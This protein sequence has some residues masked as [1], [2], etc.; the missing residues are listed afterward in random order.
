[1]TEWSP[2]TEGCQ[3]R[4]RRTGP[5]RSDLTDSQPE[6]YPPGA[7]LTLAPVLVGLVV[8]EGVLL[9]GGVVHTPA[10]RMPGGRQVGGALELTLGG[11]TVGGALVVTGELVE[12]VGVGVGVGLGLLLDTVG[13]G[14]LDAEALLPLPTICLVGSGR[15]GLPAR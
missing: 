2:H 4:T 10:M 5:I 6:S 11:G 15:F 14:V 1:M 8:G 7:G 13:T 3:T 9:A 12:C